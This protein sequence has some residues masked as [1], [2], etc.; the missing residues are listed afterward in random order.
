MVIHNGFGVR[1]RAAMCGMEWDSNGN[2]GSSL[3]VV[4]G[5]RGRRRRVAATEL[6]S[7]SFQCCLEGEQLS[8]AVPAAML[9]GVYTL[10]V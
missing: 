7:L 5:W 8:L 3:L 10:G 9:S 1:R 6:Y 2:G 4:G